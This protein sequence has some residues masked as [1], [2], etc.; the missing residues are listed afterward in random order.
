M[1]SSVPNSARLDEGII[2]VKG[3]LTLQLKASMFR[4]LSKT[5]SG[6]SVMLSGR[7]HMVLVYT[8]M[9]SFCFHFGIIGLTNYW[10]PID[11]LHAAKCAF[12]SVQDH[13]STDCRYCKQ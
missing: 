6:V 4:V 9:L 10:K 2:E 3:I 11:G 8:L 5:I 13:G 1:I 12:L 7:W